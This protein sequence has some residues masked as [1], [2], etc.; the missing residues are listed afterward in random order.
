MWVSA[1]ETTTQ[2]LILNHP[3]FLFMWSYFLNFQEH[4]YPWPVQS[5]LTAEPICWVSTRVI[6]VTLVSAECIG[7]LSQVPALSNDWWS[8][9]RIS[10]CRLNCHVFNIDLPAPAEPIAQ[11]FADRA[12]QGTEWEDGCNIEAVADL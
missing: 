6:L 3:V 1:S 12:F 2:R 5:V 7:N 4:F 9:A 10:H 11:A 8:R